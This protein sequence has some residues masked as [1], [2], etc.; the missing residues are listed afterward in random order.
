MKS[1]R[2]RRMLANRRAIAVAVVA[3]CVTVVAVM[4]L[5]RGAGTASS[6]A[7]PSF[8]VGAK[9]KTVRLTARQA[10]R[11]DGAPA[12]GSVS[13]LGI[14]GGRA[15]YRVGD[16]QSHC[17]AVGD[18]SSIG[19]LGALACWDRS[20]PLMDFSV[21]DISAG[22]TSQMRFFRIEGIAADEVASVGVLG[23]DGH[24]AARVRVVG[25]L[26][27]LPNPPASAGRGLVAL[28]GRGE[29]LAALPGP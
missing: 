5:G 10:H 11:L 6:A 16:A 21:L 29:A 19:T 15:F 28:D 20:H 3:G 25:N 24:V 13:L 18:A 9:G 22:S 23:P 2:L 27:S 8:S 12:S 1:R 7:T 4:E 17:Y 26:Y 14:R